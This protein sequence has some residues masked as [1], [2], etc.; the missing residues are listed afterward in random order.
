VAQRFSAAAIDRLPDVEVI[1]VGAG[2][3]GCAVAYELAS[4]GAAV[5]VLDVRGVARGAT[6]ASAGVLCPHI[7]GHAAALRQLGTASLAGYESFVA[8]VAA[9][10]GRG[11]EY[12][13]CGTLEV[14]LTDVEAAQLQGTAEGHARTGVEHRYLEP[15][16]ARA[17]EPSLS[18]HTMGA[19]LIPEH[20][21]VRA[22]DFTQALAAAAV[23]RGATL[24]EQTA[25]RRIVSQGSKVG[26]ESDRET[27]NADAVVIAVGSWSSALEPRAPQVKPI[28]GQLLH[29]ARESRTAWRVIWGFGCYV[30]PWQDGS[31]LVGAT[32]EDVGFDES[33]TVAGV[34]ELLDRAC[35]LLPSLRNATFRTVRVGLRPATPDDLPI[36]GP[37]ST[38]PGVFFAT[39]HYRNG[40]L[41]AP[42]TAALLADLIVDGRSAPELEL[43]APRRFGL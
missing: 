17:L 11:V 25:V 19:L 18:D 33:A 32:V 35:E 37:S 34:R 39:G 36:V 16:E 29:L 21:Y 20:G 5:R 42:L 13:R 8:R 12:Q 38:H 30:V 9:D 41:L 6:A 10:A 26:V 4:R 22:A 40:V 28:R 23:A 3:I 7:E 31:L 24:E 27:I 2:I 43:M 14:A 1:V 15:R